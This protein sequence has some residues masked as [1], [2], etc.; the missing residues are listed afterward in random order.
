MKRDDYLAT[1]FDWQPY[2][3]QFWQKKQRKGCRS[4]WLTALNPIHFDRRSNVRDAIHVDWQPSIKSILKEGEGPSGV[5]CDWQK[6]A[7]TEGALSIWHGPRSCQKWVWGK[8]HFT[9]LFC[10]MG[11]C[12]LTNLTVFFIIFSFI[13][14]ECVYCQTTVIHLLLS[15]NSS[16]KKRKTLNKGNT[17][18]D[19]AK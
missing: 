12:L 6:G 16:Q 5:H 3:Y 4:C 2:I 14:L 10:S 17:A 7:G 13:T 15:K 8:P 9:S 19:T 18:I 11:N 1:H